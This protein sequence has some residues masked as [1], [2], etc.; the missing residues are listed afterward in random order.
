MQ[1]QSPIPL[2]IRFKSYLI[3]LIMA[4]CAMLSNILALLLGPFLDKKRLFPF[5]IGSFSYFTVTA[6]R[7]ICGVQFELIGQQNLPKDRSKGNVIMSNHQSSWETFF[8]QLVF[9]PN[10][11]ILKREL[12]FIPFFGW[13]LILMRPIFINRSDRREAMNQVLTKGTERLQNGEDILIFPEGTRMPIHQQKSF[14]KSGAILATKAGVDII[15]VAHNAG[16]C[17]PARSG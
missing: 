13:A 11:V 2:S 9:S 17:W 15:P 3:Y 8:L 14:S 10:T 7:W 5:V 12:A 6:T 16:I 4:L 1:P